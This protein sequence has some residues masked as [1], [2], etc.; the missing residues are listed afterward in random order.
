[1]F[2]RFTTIL[3]ATCMRRVR[4]LAFGLAFLAS[5]LVATVPAASQS[6]STPEVALGWASGTQ[7]NPGDGAAQYSLQAR[8]RLAPPG[9]AWTL[10]NS[11]NAYKFQ[12]ASPGAI[13]TDTVT[14]TSLPTTATGSAVATRT[15]NDFFPYYNMSITGHLVLTPP[16][17]QTDPP[18]YIQGQFWVRDPIGY[19]VGDVGTNL[20]ATVSLLAG[21]SFLGTQ[22]EPG[23]PNLQLD[24]RFGVGSSFSASDPST[25]WGNSGPL[26]TP[27]PANAFDL[28]TISLMQN[29]AGTGVLAVVSPDPSSSLA[30]FNVSSSNTSGQIESLIEGADWV[31]SG[32]MWTLESNLPLYQITLTNAQDNND[33]I[34]LVIGS[35]F[36]D[37]AE[38]TSVPEPSTLALLVTGIVVLS[39][40][41]LW[42]RS[43]RSQSAKGAVG[44]ASSL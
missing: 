41:V 11:V 19:T 26:I 35:F 36:S 2:A 43:F 34:P 30:G 32:D 7:W 8:F 17:P 44:S 29:S 21:T 3:S 20:T 39:G 6:V 38:L 15:Y 18:T 13:Q 40:R 1:M 12:G 28:R 5:P 42:R 14:V 9:G 16:T 25:L 4:N 10:S 24:T 33:G 23:N 37:A 22:I 31:H 27:P